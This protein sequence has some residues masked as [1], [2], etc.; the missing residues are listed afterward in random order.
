MSPSSP[1]HSLGA[2]AFKRVI[3]LVVN[4]S[5]F[6]LLLSV[7]FPLDLSAYPFVAS[8]TNYISIHIYPILLSTRRSSKKKINQISICETFR[9]RNSFLIF[10]FDISESSIGTLKV[11]SYAQAKGVIGHIEMSCGRH[12]IIV[13]LAA[14]S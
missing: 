9:I 1:L 14:G 4:T 2:L 6:F 12:L 5:F 8:R 10:S 13:Q 11:W 7:F 3:F